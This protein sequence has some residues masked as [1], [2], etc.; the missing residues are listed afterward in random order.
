MK[1]TCTNFKK[2]I[3]MCRAYLRECKG[4]FCRA[5]ESKLNPFCKKCSDFL[6]QRK[7]RLFGSRW[8]RDVLAEE[9]VKEAQRKPQ[10]VDVRSLKK[11]PQCGIFID[12]EEA[13]S[14]IKEA[15]FLV[16]NETKG[17]FFR[18]LFVNLERI[19]KFSPKENAEPWADYSFNHISGLP[20]D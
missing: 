20:G 17:W 4:G 19:G 18:A 10:E 16:F 1:Q 6:A 8:G 3:T 13:G 15:G 9:K 12:L 14:Y 5:C 11:K 2:P 7:T